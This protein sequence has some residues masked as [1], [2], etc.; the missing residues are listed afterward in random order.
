MSYFNFVLRAQG[1]Q[2]LVVYYRVVGSVHGYGGGRL[3]SA[4]LYCG[5]FMVVRVNVPFPGPWWY[6][7][8]SSG[9]ILSFPSTA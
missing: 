1:T 9:P 7:S 5:F 8:T 2:F 6:I 4:G 3:R